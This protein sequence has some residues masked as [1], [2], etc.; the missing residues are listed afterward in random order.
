LAVLAVV[1]HAVA[2]RVSIKRIRIL[3]GGG[4]D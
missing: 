1:A 2:A 3:F 4:L